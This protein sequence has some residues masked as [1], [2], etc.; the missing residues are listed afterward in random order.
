MTPKM[1]APR[2][3]LAAV[4]VAAGAVGLVAGPASSGGPPVLEATLVPNPAQ[5]DDDV[6]AT[7]ATA[8][9]NCPIEL[10]VNGVGTAGSSGLILEWALVDDSSTEIDGGTAPV[11][12]E[13]AWEV[14]FTAPGVGVYDFVAACVLELVDVGVEAAGFSAVA[15]YEEQ[16]VVEGVAPVEFDATLDQ[17]SG[18]P[19]D[20]IELTGVNCS[21]THGAAALLPV[22]PAPAHPDEVDEG[23][24]QQYEIIDGQFGGVVPVPDDAAPGTYQVVVWC[25]DE[26]LVEDTEVLGYTITAPGAVPVPAAP[27]FTG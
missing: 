2:A 18:P 4:L 16:L 17:A 12:A 25:M 3:A 21:G 7:P 11:G 20:D 26:D 19:G 27:T 8:G 22:G 14:T 24:L 9:D 23:I 1:T 10:Q 5:P 6:T 13:G 15:T